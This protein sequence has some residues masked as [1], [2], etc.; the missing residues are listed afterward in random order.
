MNLARINLE[1]ENPRQRSLTRMN[2]RRAVRA[3]AVC[4]F[5][6]AACASF[7]DATTKATDP[8]FVNRVRDDTPARMEKMFA[9]T[10]AQ[11]GEEINEAGVMSELKLRRL[12]GRWL[13]AALASMIGDAE[14]NAMDAAFAG[15][16]QDGPSV[17][18]DARA[19]G[20]VPLID[21]AGYQRLV[22][23]HKGRPLVVN[24]WATWCVPCRKE[25][26]VLIEVAKEYQWKG[27][28]F[29]GISFDE[30][31]TT[32]AIPDFL[33]IYRPVF[34]NYQKDPKTPAAALDHAIDP[35]WSG[36]LPSTIFYKRNGEMDAQF[37]G[38]QT[39]ANFEREI[40]RLLK[41]TNPFAAKPAAGG[42]K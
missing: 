22:A 16:V 11:R 33:A 26:P 2:L 23:R 5:C 15:S 10:T 29:A 40:E 24:F 30:A 14:M 34:P 32:S 7:G 6:A 31:A 18:S 9:R 28:V 38:P 37:Y 8:V 1:Q 3:I 39:R 19:K 20:A 36:G 41:N 17:K 35:A 4:G 21:V 25:Y 12:G 27:A 42:G 13:Y